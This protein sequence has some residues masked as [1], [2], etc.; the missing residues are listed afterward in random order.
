MLTTLLA[1]NWEPELRGVL[2]LIIG[3]AVLFPISE[4]TRIWFGGTGGAEDLMIYGAL[5]LVIAVA[6]PG[7]LIALFRRLFGGGAHA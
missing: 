5:I 6:Y 1:V 4:L 2:I 3:T 7:G